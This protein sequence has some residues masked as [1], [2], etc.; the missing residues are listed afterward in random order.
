VVAEVALQL[1]EDARDREARE[2]GAPGRVVAVDSL[3]QPD[4]RDLQ[5]VVERLAGARV[6][7]GQPACERQAPPDQLVAGGEVPA[8]AVALEQA[9]LLET[10]PGGAESGMGDGAA[11]IAP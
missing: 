4:A 9:R 3:D 7:D 2:R 1:A 6:A 5:Q 11:G 10:L 8:L